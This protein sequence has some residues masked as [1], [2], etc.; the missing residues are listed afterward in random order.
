MTASYNTD[1][2]IT[3]E[4]A[5]G[6]DVFDTSPTWVDITDDVRT[7]S[8]VRGRSRVIDQ[9][10]AGQALLT[11]SNSSGDYNPANTA[12]THYPGVRVMN[13]IRIQ[14]D[15]DST[16]YDLF[17]G[18]VETWNAEFPSAAKD[19]V[20]VVKC[21]DGFRL[22]AMYEGDWTQSAALSGTRVGNILTAVGWPAGWR[23]IDSGTH[24]VAALSTEFDTALSQLHRTAL[25]EQGLF[26]IAGDGDAT[27]RDGNTR[28]E[29]Q[30]SVAETFS[31]DGSDLKYVDA[32]LVYDDSQLWNQATVTRIDGEAQTS[33]DSTSVGDYGQRDLH[34]SSTLHYADG[35]AFSLAGWLVMEHGNVL[36]RVPE[37]TVKPERDPSNL[38]APV[39]SLELLDRVNVEKTLPGDD[40]DDDFHVEG[41]SHNVR[42]VGGRS[43][44]TTFQLSPKLPH[45]DW[46]ILGTSEL[47]TDTRLGY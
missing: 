39:L 32:H 10:Q 25:V 1:V 19:N 42:M 8:T 37:L 20:S 41:V 35:E 47:G 33:T 11:V 18:F 17:R 43:W 27:F 2:D 22:F 30:A 46:W 3:I 4:V 45:D 28:I 7:F 31:D 14:A 6:D 5:F 23:D 16:T 24:T 21:I 15:Y 29:D 34:L 36:V 38:W 44:E 9:M 12:G 26:F 13:P 40:F